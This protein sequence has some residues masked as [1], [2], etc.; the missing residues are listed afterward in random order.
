MSSVKDVDQM[1]AGAVSYDQPLPVL[2]QS[3]KIVQTDMMAGAW[4]E[5]G[6]QP[7]LRNCPMSPGKV[8]E[9][10]GARSQ[11]VEVFPAVTGYVNAQKDHRD[12][13]LNCINAKL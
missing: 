3:G 8:Q 7:D 12:D 10:G 5:C 4:T 11:G 2:N 13:R 6:K 1:F 9:I